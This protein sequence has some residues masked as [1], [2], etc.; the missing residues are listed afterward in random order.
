M[1]ELILVETALRSLVLSTEPDSIVQACHWIIIIVHLGAPHQ[2]RPHPD[3][4]Q[5]SQGAK[6]A[7]Y[8][9]K[10]SVSSMI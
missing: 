3:R 9:T 10:I 8:E 5:A 7:W 6:Y 4:E 2:N 1:K